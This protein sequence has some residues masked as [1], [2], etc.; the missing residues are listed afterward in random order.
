MNKIKILFILLGFIPV[1]FISCGVQQEIS[2][3]VNGSGSTD[4]TVELDPVFVYY[5][6]DLTEA[7]SDPGSVEKVDI[8]KIEEIKK[9]INEK[10]GASVKKIASPEQKSLVLSFRF[11]DI[12]QLLTPGDKNVRDIISFSTNNNRNR[13]H[14][15]LEKANYSKLTDLF[16][17]LKNQVFENLAPQVDE[18]IP[19]AEYLDIIEFAMGEEGP[20]AVMSSVITIKVK[21]QG[22]IISQKGG[23]VKDGAVLFRIPLLRVC[24]LNQPLDFEVEYT[25]N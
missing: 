13:I 11:S 15:H 7:F 14:F 5:I 16:P 12:R 23:T 25:G 9:Q 20:P 10:P 21:V 24:L 2:I 22:K 19:A 17:V 18:D 8:F 1:I 4:L 6:L 3:S